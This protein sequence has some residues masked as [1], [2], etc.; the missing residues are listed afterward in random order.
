MH[1]YELYKK[2][3]DEWEL[4]G[5]YSRIEGIE[6]RIGL[7]DAETLAALEGEE[8]RQLYRIEFSDE[9]MR[10]WIVEDTVE[11]HGNVRCSEIAGF[12]DVRPRQVQKIIASAIKKMRCAVSVDTKTTVFRHYEMQYGKISPTRI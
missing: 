3:G 1:K 11:R 6:K 5:K 4:I 12:Y 7:S 2:N 8:V 9:V 10:D